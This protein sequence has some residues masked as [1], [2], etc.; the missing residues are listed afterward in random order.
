MA[1]YL[2]PALPSHG[3][4]FCLYT[5]RRIRS[6]IG[7]SN[8]MA[9]E[10]SVTRLVQ[11]L[12]NGEESIAESKLF[13]RYFSKLIALARQRL[14]NSPGCAEDEEDVALSAM[15]SFFQRA[16]SGAFPDLRNR[17]ELWGLLVTI[18]SR[19]AINQF[20]RQT[21]AKRNV[22]TELD[23]KN[24]GPAGL[25]GLASADPTPEA[26]M[27]LAEECNLRIRALDNEVL[28][29]VALMRLEGYSNRE[30]A[31]ELNVAERTVRRKLHRIRHEWLKTIDEG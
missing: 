19:K 16:R 23:K 20:K 8:G 11:I 25:D 4:W 3:L 9:S 18:T 14:H 15:D 2:S 21:A 27:Q 7:V 31:E 28:R 29:R 12:G 1:V 24:L 26:V 22:L 13:E 17:S 5:D 6:E 10:G 30:V